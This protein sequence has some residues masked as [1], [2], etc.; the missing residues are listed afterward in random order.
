MAQWLITAA[1]D[2]QHTPQAGSTHRGNTFVFHTVTHLIT[3]HSA[4]GRGAGR[5]LPLKRA[6]SAPIPM[7]AKRHERATGW[8]GTDPR[9]SFDAKTMLEV[10]EQM[11]D[12]A[13][14]TDSA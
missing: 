5:A 3:V 10:F 4:R 1:R 12:Q 7:V 14:A 8:I 2:G 6:V 11:R 9:D 13:S